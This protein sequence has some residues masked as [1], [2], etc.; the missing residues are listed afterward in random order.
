MVAARY[1]CRASVKL[2]CTLGLPSFRTG[3]AGF[4]Y[5]VPTPDPIAGAQLERID[6]AAH[7][8]FR[9]GAADDHFVLDDEWRHGGALAS[10]HVDEDLLPHQFAITGIER[11]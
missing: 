4:G 10:T 9:A 6:V 8:V 2:P 5:G 7:A 11:N 1:P 3:L